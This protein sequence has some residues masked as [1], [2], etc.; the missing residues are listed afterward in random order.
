MKRSLTAVLMLGAFAAVTLTATPAYGQL[1]NLVKKRLPKGATAEAGAPEFNDVTLEITQERID[2]LLA[3]KQAAKR[4]ATGPDGPA[5]LQAKID[6]LDD[7]QTAIYSKQVNAINGWD[8]R[9][10]DVENCRA[11]A[12]TVIRDS[13]QPTMQNMQKMQQ[14][15]LAMAAAQQKGD[16]AE[17]RRLLDQLK[18]DRE[19]TSADT[20]AVIKKCGDSTPPPIV[21][22][23][24]GL[25][26]QID[27]LRNQ[28]SKSEAE[29]DRIE[30][31]SGLNARQRAVSCER[32]KMFIEQL[33]KKQAWAGF[34]D[35]EI[36]AMQNR[37][38]AIKD[39]DALCP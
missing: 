16:T 25:K 9:R 12:Y 20:A 30:N 31:T 23:W 1:G 5:T 4:Y 34:S 24:L 8:E 3:A 18:G 38:Q 7:R 14:I 22:E 37:E 32:I 2:K 19:P 28:L 11:D 10:R 35:A 27:G 21:K 15:G 17:M 13:R 26:D 6:P 33:K 29:V 39:L 36:K